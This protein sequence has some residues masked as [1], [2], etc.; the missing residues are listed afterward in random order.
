MELRGIPQSRS[1]LFGVLVCTAIAIVAGLFA[2]FQ[3]TRS[4]SIWPAIPPAIGVVMMVGMLSVLTLH[5]FKRER[6]V[7]DK[8]TKT[9]EH[10]TW[11]MLFGSR[12]SM[13][14]PFDRIH[15][16][17]IQRSLE[18]S[19]GGKGFP[20]RVTKARIL[21]SKPRRA[22]EL[23]EVQSGSEGPVESLAKKVS[24]FLA[25]PLERVGSHDD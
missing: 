20:I 9:A 7:L 1:L 19:G 18:S 16:I 25:R 14:Y 2:Y 13:T 17:A 22:I 10:Q 15:S 12:R 4:K 11:S 3:W 24:E 6:L 5:S 23:D 21:I 8:V